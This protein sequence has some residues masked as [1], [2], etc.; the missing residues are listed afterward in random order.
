MVRR[1]RY[2]IT[3]DEGYIYFGNIK[4]KATESKIG[5]H[6]L[7]FIDLVAVG[8]GGPTFGS[9]IMI[10]SRAIRRVSCLTYHSSRYEYYIHINADWRRYIKMSPSTN[11]NPDCNHP[12]LRKYIT[13]RAKAEHRKNESVMQQITSNRSAEFVRFDFS[14]ASEVRDRHRTDGD[15]S[16]HYRPNSGPPVSGQP[17]SAEPVPLSGTINQATASSQTENG[18]ELD[19]GSVPANA[20]QNGTNGDGVQVDL[21]NCVLLYQVAIQ[22]RAQRLL[23]NVVEFVADIP[24]D[25][26]WPRGLIGDRDE[27]IRNRAVARRPRVSLPRAQTATSRRT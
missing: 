12:D 20:D 25:F 22:F 8:D 4:C 13:V 27:Y 6:W 15:Y 7:E 11:F 14:L 23:Q 9:P 21:N 5:L 1:D 16:P 26:S 24:I 10:P 3:L 19:S 17:P 18:G 2:S